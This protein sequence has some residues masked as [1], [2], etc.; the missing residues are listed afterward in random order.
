MIY[1]AGTS[2]SIYVGD[3]LIG[4][5]TYS[6]FSTSTTKFTIGKNSSSQ[7]VDSFTLKSFKVYDYAKNE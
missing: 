4:S 3:T 7:D 1:D 6:S 5:T 2:Y